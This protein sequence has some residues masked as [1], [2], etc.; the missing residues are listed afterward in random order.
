MSNFISD[1]PRNFKVF[2]NLI[3]LWGWMVLPFKAKASD[4]LI[5]R[6]ERLE[7]SNAAR[8]TVVQGDEFRLW[9]DGVDWNSKPADSAKGGDRGW[10]IDG[11]WLR[12]DK[13]T[14]KELKVQQPRLREIRLKGAVFLQ[15]EDTLRS[16]W[17]RIGISGVGNV[18]LTLDAEEIMADLNGVGRLALQGRCSKARIDINGPGI[19]DA[20]KCKVRYAKVFIEGLGLCKIDVTDSLYAE[21]SGGGSIRYRQ[22]PGYLVN[23]ISGLGS[24]AAWENDGVTEK[25]ASTTDPKESNAS[26]RISG[27]YWAGRKVGEPRMP[28]LELGLAHWV[29]R[30]GSAGGNRWNAS[31]EPYDI[32]ELEGEKSWFL[33]WWTPFQGQACL[34]GYGA[35]PDRGWSQGKDTRTDPRAKPGISI[36]ARGAM[37]LSYQNFRFED[38]LVLS[39]GS[40]SG[41]HQTLSATLI[42]TPGSPR[43]DRSR[44]ENLQLQIPLMIHFHYGRRPHKGWH[45]GGGIVPGIRLWTRSLNRYRDDGGRVELYRTGNFYLNPFALALRSEIGRGRFRM[46][47]QYSLNSMFKPGYG[48]RVNRVDWGVTLLSY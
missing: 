41:G 20:K 3:F 37:A 34:Y 11:E 2:L 13:F 26:G 38:N 46:F 36:W 31:P 35:F 25:P 45:V 21:I 39:K 32:M 27:D 23:R 43:F 6:W 30:S 5:F 15:S 9:V 28:A 19:L 12:I 48:P 4:S 47:T 22:E 24:I 33:N 17:L 18:D 7:I 1:L 42:D 40:D 29:S 44:L 10:E 8:V 14:A 16:D